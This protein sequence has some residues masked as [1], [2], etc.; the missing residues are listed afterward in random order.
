MLG[1]SILSRM[2][3]RKRYLYGLISTLL[4]AVGLVRAAER[5]DP[6]KQSSV[7]PLPIVADAILS[8]G[9][10]SINCHAIDNVNGVHSL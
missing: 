3:T 7:R 10:C 2:N 8:T 6:V 1:G 5:F 4:F 9:S